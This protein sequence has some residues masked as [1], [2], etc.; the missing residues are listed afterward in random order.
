M[1]ATEIRRL[2]FWSEVQGLERPAHGEP[3]R[4]SAA[5][6][7]KS[8]GSAGKHV[9]HGPYR[10]ATHWAAAGCGRNVAVSSRDPVGAHP[11]R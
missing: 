5:T 3:L 1:D 10:F 2:T 9:D 6:W 11:C 7:P 4:A 8:H